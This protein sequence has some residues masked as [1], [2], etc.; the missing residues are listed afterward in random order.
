MCQIRWGDTANT[1]QPENG[2]IMKKTK[3]VLICLAMLAVIIIP[4]IKRTVVVYEGSVAEEKPID[5]IRNVSSEKNIN[6]RVLIEIAKAESELRQFNK[7]GSVLR[8]YINPD[9]VGIFQINEYFWLEKS[10]ELG[11]DIYSAKGNVEMAI[12]IFMH[13][14]T[15]PWNWSKSKWGKEI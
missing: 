3:F 9:D 4:N 10:K 13:H 6:P 2:A 5:I 7:D 11:L 12:W 14:G 1:S 8:G 15:D